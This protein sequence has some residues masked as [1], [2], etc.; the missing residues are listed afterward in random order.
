MSIC[1]L[2]ICIYLNFNLKFQ[3]Y[4]DFFLYKNNR[5]IINYGSCYDKKLC[6]MTGWLEKSWCDVKWPDW[7]LDS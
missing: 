7:L 1:I 2:V 5:F 4:R 6:S 3:E